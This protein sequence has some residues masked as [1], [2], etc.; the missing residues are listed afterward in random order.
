MVCLCACVECVV[1]VEWDEFVDWGGGFMVQRYKRL[2]PQCT[3]NFNTWSLLFKNLQIYWHDLRE[4]VH[5]WKFRYTCSLN[6]RH[7][8]Q[9]EDGWL[10]IW[11]NNAISHI[12]NPSNNMNEIMILMTKKKGI[13][14][15]LL[16]LAFLVVVVEFSL[17]F[18]TVIVPIR[19][20]NI[21]NRHTD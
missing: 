16:L 1:C 2:C 4:Y 19:N 7:W 15:L 10:R 21:M 12:K 20:Q 5:V 18:T 13:S 11:Y 17:G 6:R 9:H 8:R 14:P 3:Y